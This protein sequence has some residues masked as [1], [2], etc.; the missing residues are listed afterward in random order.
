MKHLKFFSLTLATI[1][2]SFLFC[3]CEKEPDKI[4]VNEPKLTRANTENSTP[5]S[6]IREYAKEQ[7]LKFENKLTSTTKK[8]RTLYSSND[9]DLLISNISNERSTDS[10]DNQ[11]EI[12][13]Y[14]SNL[15][16]D[17]LTRINNHP[18]IQKIIEYG[19]NLKAK[20]P[21]TYFY[22]DPNSFEIIVG[23][24]TFHKMEV[25]KAYEYGYFLSE[26]SPIEY[27]RIKNEK[28]SLT[29]SSYEHGKAWETPI[30]VR[31]G[32]SATTS[33]INNMRSAMNT[34][35]T[36]V[37]AITFTEIKNNSTN[38]FNW[39]MGFSKH[40]RIIACED[41]NSGGSSTIGSKL[42]AKIE[43]TDGEGTSTCIHEMCHCLGVI[44]EHQRPDRDNYININLNNVMPGYEHN[45]E[46]YSSDDYSIYGSFDFQS[47]MI[48]SSRAFSSNGGYTMTKK[49]GS[50]IYS[51]SSLST[52]DIEGLRYF[53][54]NR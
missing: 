12:D 6:D 22:N 48:Y 13:N 1:A 19:N 7:V 35:T 52:L 4:S 29:R 43:I 39:N 28:E 9:F 32:N 3:A 47:I 20:S 14:Y 54:G 30:K 40:V 26:L 10:Y 49:D 21:Q 53:Y 42:W 15:T 31:F 18:A 24:R 44:H 11:T 34:I 41:E 37:P 17:V 27:E 36:N 25:L 51:Y 50:Y 16:K 2:I 46:K 45:F 5:Y 23:S 33:I 8:Q 38:Q